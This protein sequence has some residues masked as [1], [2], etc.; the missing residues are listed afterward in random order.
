MSVHSKLLLRSSDTE[1]AKVQLKGSIFV[2]EDKNMHILF[3]ILSSFMLPLASNS[4]RTAERVN[5]SIQPEDDSS[6]II[7]MLCCCAYC[8]CSSHPGV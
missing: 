3:Y 6:Y 5:L 1:E 8:T 7:Y 4:L 2:A